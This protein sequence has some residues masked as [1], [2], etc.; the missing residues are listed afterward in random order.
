M[1]LKVAIVLLAAVE[2]NIRA[3]RV[4]DLPSDQL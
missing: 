4:Q 3:M 2:G 1:V